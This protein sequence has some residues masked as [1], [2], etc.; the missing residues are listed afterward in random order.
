MIPRELLLLTRPAE[1]PS[2]LLLT[3]PNEADRVGSGS[4]PGFFA[5]IFC[6][7]IHVYSSLL[8][9]VLRFGFR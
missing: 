7:L 6:V 4:N 5:A 1:A 9:N 2:I 8:I 3:R